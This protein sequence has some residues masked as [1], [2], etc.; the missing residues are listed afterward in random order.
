MTADEPANGSR[1]AGWPSL[2]GMGS[3]ALAGLLWIVLVAANPYG[4]PHELGPRLISVG[5]LAVAATAF[6]GA[7]RRRALTVLV[8]FF[9]SFVP[10]G[11]YLL[12]TPGP[13][14]LIG[15]ADL[16]LLAAALGLFWRRRR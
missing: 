9:V 10:I 14:A 12:G 3:A 11:L 15:V 2:L 7:L 4:R 1:A 6:Y 8:A 13:F 5:M 16:G